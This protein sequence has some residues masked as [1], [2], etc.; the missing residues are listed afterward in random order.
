MPD[1][2]RKHT[3]WRVTGELRDE[4]LAWEVF[5]MLAEAKVLTELWRQK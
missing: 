2:H 1:D 3:T 4:L 5:D